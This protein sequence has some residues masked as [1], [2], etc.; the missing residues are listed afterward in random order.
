M[1]CIRAVLVPGPHPVGPFDGGEHSLGAPGLVHRLTRLL[2]EGIHKPLADLRLCLV[3][4]WPCAQTV[5]KL[6][7]SWALC[8]GKNNNN[9]ETQ[10]THKTPATTTHQ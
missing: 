8:L 3:G 9:K 5:T 7:T 2:G 6:L 1:S 10:H 4:E